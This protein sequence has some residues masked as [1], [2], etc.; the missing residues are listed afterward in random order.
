ME[1]LME[2]Q[3]KVLTC[4][5]CGQTW[6]WEATEQQFF[7]EKGFTKEPACHQCRQARRANIR[8]DFE[9]VCSAC[10]AKCFVPFEPKE[11]RPVY[12]STCYANIRSK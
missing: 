3:D 4:K 9:A 12:C 8:Q 1:Y 6:T 10:G 7:A 5:K 2:F 11:G